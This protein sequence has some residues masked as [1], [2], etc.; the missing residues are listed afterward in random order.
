MT[1]PTDRGRAVGLTLGAVFALLTALLVSSLAFAPRAEAYIYW[2]N[3]DT[4]T[5][6]RA[7]LNGTGVELGFLDVTRGPMTVDARHIYWVTGKNG[8]KVAR[9]RIDGTGI[10]RSYVTGIASEVCGRVCAGYV[11]DVAVGAGHIYGAGVLGIGRAKLDGTGVDPDFIPGA[12]GGGSSLAVGAD[13][14]YWTE[15]AGY[16]GTIGRAN[17]DGTGV[18]EQFISGLGAGVNRVVDIAA[19]AGHLYWSYYSCPAR[20]C[21]GAI[22]RANLDG[23]GVDQNF[24]NLALGI[25]PPLP[26]PS[27]GAV[28]RG[29]AVDD[30]HIYWN[31]WFEGTIGRANLDGTGVDSQFLS[32]D[33]PVYVAVNAL[34]P[35]GKVTA[36]RTQ[37][38]KSNKIRVKVRVKAKQ[39]LTARATGKVEINPTYSL[40]PATMKVAKGRAK[41]LKLKPKNKAQAKKIAAALKRGEKATAKVKVKLTGRGENRE[42]EK[43][44]VRLKR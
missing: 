24:I 20:P 21:T 4:Q 9:A 28:A 8:D 7:K 23:S 19:D 17:L 44:R 43:L 6:G 2:T 36:D 29:L 31:N 37:R 42:T 13:H 32:V 1:R 14:I 15:G 34:R 26:M 3:I 35:V 38:Q 5:M 11:L 16:A 39:R 30:N 18:N 33:Y 40:S 22:G 12:A 27:Q 10:D 41:L 25:E